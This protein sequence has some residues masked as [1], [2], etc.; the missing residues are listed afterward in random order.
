MAAIVSVV[1]SQLS[2]QYVPAPKRSKERCIFYIG[3]RQ[4]TDLLLES[5]A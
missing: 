3:I 1:I 2:A 5:L 4:D